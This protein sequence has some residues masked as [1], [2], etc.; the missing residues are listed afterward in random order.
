MKQ[1]INEFKKFTETKFM[2]L[3]NHHEAIC[4]WFLSVYF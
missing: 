2:K 1:K 4:G 3:S